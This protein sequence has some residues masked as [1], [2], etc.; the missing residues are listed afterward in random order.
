MFEFIDHDDVHEKCG[1]FMGRF[2]DD[3]EIE[4]LEVIELPNRSD[5]PLEAYRIGKSDLDRAYTTRRYPKS[6]VVGVWHTHPPPFSK[7]PS[8]ADWD[9]TETIPSEWWSAIYHPA[10]REIVWYDITGITI[11]END[12]A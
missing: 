3:G 5:R 2:L 9:A 8:E 12:D 7:W 6:A 10:T 4:V 11:E 1:V